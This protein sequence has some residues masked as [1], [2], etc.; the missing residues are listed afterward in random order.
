MTLYKSEVL[1][2]ILKLQRELKKYNIVSFFK[3]N[4]FRDYMA[5]LTLVPNGTLLIYYKPTKNTYSLKKQLQNSNVD[6]IIDFVWSKINSCEIY[7]AGSGVYEAFVDG[8]YISGIVGYGV[9][10]YLG[11]KIKAEL[12]GTVSSIHFRQF[13]GELQSVIETIKW[14]ENNGVKNVRINYD[15]VGIENFVTGKWKAKNSFSKKYVDFVLKTKIEI[16]WRHIK[17]HTGNKKNDLADR[18]AKKAIAATKN[19]LFKIS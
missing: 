13:G 15:Y 14:C 17:S 6:N 18:L 5:S 12:L 11:N 16:E 19:E 9:V 1:T 7:P 4:S 3:K 10:I 8:S 2:M